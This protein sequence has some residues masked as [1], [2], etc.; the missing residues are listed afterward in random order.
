MS[1]QAGFDPNAEQANNGER[2]GAEAEFHD[3]L[4]R[5]VLVLAERSPN[6]S[7]SVR[8]L[9][10]DVDEDFGMSIT[11]NR[12]PN[13]REQ[14]VT[15]DIRGV[16]G[17]MSLKDGVASERYGGHSGDYVPW[18]VIAANEDLPPEVRAIAVRMQVLKGSTDEA[19]PITEA[20]ISSIANGAWETN[21]S[22]EE[23]V[24]YNFEQSIATHLGIVTVSANSDMPIDG[25][26]L[27]TDKKLASHMRVDLSMWG[28]K[29]GFNYYYDHTA[30]NPGIRETFKVDVDED[31][32]P[33]LSGLEKERNPYIVV[34]A[35]DIKNFRVLPEFVDSLWEE[36]EANYTGDEVD[37][38][39]GKFAVVNREEE[40]TDLAVQTATW[41][42]TEAG[43]RVAAEERRQYELAVSSHTH[44]E[45][46]P[47]QK[48]RVLDALSAALE[49]SE[50]GKPRDG[51]FKDTHE[52][53]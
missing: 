26:F 19:P 25:E 12:N 52:G 6:T 15:F 48:Q 38:P 40:S 33:P 2:K 36:S 9:Y 31:K 10:E 18:H 20:Y 1:E 47:E 17:E 11:T 37:A 27:P 42:D 22:R 39:E 35:R 24:Y 34:S 53:E 21:S 3:K 5:G 30:H 44:S 23:P 8:N 41:F 49:S 51:I 16:Y 32:L 4:Q 14:R 45:T 50:T 29:G 43:A 46:T 7:F 13:T 28:L